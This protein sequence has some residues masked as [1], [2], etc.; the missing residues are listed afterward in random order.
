MTR[1]YLVKG[2]KLSQKAYF[3]K[4]STPWITHGGHFIFCVFLQKIW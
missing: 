3:I 1:L 2:D 4:I